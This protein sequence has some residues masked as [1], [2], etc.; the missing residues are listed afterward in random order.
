MY[1]FSTAL[2]NAGF[3]LINL[4]Y[5]SVAYQLL[6]AQM[7]GS[8]RIR[9]MTYLNSNW[10]LVGDSTSTGDFIWVFDTSDVLTFSLAVPLWFGGIQYS[11]L[12]LPY[13]G[14]NMSLQSLTDLSAWWLIANNSGSYS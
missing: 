7:G 6:P 10:Y 1:A 12:T 14:A 5:P 11:T 8:F 4:Y 13:K 9:A 3:N 2:S